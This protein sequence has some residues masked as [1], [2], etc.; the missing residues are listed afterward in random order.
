[1]LTIIDIDVCT[2][3]VFVYLSNEVDVSNERV[4]FIIIVSIVKPTYNT[5][6]EKLIIIHSETTILIPAPG[7]VLSDWRVGV[8]NEGVEDNVETFDGTAVVVSLPVT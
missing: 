8:K 3:K 1:M 4:F 5:I 2:K 6:M 7:V